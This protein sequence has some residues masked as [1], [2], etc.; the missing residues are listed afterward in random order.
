M[1]QLQKRQNVQKKRFW[2]KVPGVNGLNAF[3]PFTFP[4]WRLMLQTNRYSV[5]GGLRS[6]VCFP[7]P[8]MNLQSQKFKLLA[9]MCS[10]GTNRSSTLVNSSPLPPDVSNCTFLFI[11]VF[12]PFQFSEDKNKLLSYWRFGSDWKFWVF[13]LLSRALSPVGRTAFWHA[14]PISE[15]QNNTLHSI[16][17]FPFASR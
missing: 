3:P 1:I 5:L 11:F 4:K 2:Q 6:P 12:L 9:D 15:S 8:Q 7:T 10:S 16:Y 13:L 14:C 17:C